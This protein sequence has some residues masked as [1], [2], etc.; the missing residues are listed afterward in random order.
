MKGTRG[1]RVSE[2]RMGFEGERERSLET[3]K[4]Q[5]H[6][7]RKGRQRSVVHIGNNTVRQPYGSPKT[8]IIKSESQGAFPG[9]Y[10]WKE[11]QNLGTKQVKCR[12]DVLKGHLGTASTPS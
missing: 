1:S 9:A 11:W 4:Q 3:A 10:R 8:Q 6:K 7:R 5:R 12:T 2:C